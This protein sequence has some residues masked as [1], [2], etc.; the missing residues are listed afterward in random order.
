MIDIVE[1]RNRGLA[2][3][4]HLVKVSNLNRI[5]GDLTPSFSLYSDHDVRPICPVCGHLMGP[6]GFRDVRSHKYKAVRNAYSYLEFKCGNCSS[7]FR[8]DPFIWKTDGDAYTA[9]EAIVHPKEV[10]FFKDESEMDKYICHSLGAFDLEDDPHWLVF[11]IPLILLFCLAVAL[12]VVNKTPSAS[13]GVFGLQITAE[14]IK[15]GM[16]V[17][18]AISII[19]YFINKLKA[20]TYARFP[21]DNKKKKGY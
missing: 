14:M 11:V 21:N 5:K 12:A 7:T 13:M 20:G 15:N 3:H 1:N 16:L 6:D 9:K 19:Y 18:S 4:V 8:T 2:G 17:C 10:Y